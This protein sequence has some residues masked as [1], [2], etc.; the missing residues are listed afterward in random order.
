MIRRLN[1]TGRIKISRSDVRITTADTDN[2]AVLNA[3]LRLSGYDLPPEARVYIEA[4]HQTT[5]MRFP[6]GTVV[7]INPPEPKDRELSEFDSL[8]GVLFRVKVT[9]SHD[10]HILLASADRI[11][12][13]SPEDDANK[14]SILP[15]YPEALG[16][17]LW[18]VDMEAE[19]RLLVNKNAVSDWRQLATSDIFIALVYPVVLR[20]IL[21]SILIK[22]KHRDTDDKS[23]WR[24]RWLKFASILPGMD[25]KPPEDTED[26]DMV[27]DW[28][29]A[30]VRAFA[31]KGSLKDKFVAAWQQR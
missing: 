23:D 7:N 8:E 22:E 20:Q 14:E 25:P 29:E 16:D 17:E 19:P 11:P 1:Y 6:F 12:L 30:A 3:D 4:Y 27:S 9:Q 13:A 24:S 10:E 28:V 15:V 26:V 21:T 5:W 18:K 2:K 31:R